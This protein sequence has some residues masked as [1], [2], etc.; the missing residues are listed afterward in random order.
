MFNPTTTF[1]TSICCTSY[2]FYFHSTCFYIYTKIIIFCGLSF[3]LTLKKQISVNL[4]YCYENFTFFIL[5]RVFNLF[6]WRT[7][8]NQTA[9]LIFLMLNR[10]AFVLKFTLPCNKTSF[11]VLKSSFSKIF[12]V[13]SPQP[14]NNLI[15]NPART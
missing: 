14:T 11:I 9:W 5:K 10:K 3:T 12:F 8:V 4:L 2:I 6:S 15:N 7:K 13:A 1:T